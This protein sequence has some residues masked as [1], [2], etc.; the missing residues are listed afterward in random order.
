M[1]N[2]IIRKKSKELWRKISPTI[3]NLSPT[4]ASKMLYTLSTRK[5]LNI[6]NPTTFNE[7]LMWLKLNWQNPLVVKCADKYE[8]RDYVKSCGHENILTKL[9]GVYQSPDEIIWSDLPDKFAMKCTHG[10]GF[11]IIC[12]NKDELNK[13]EAINKLEQWMKTRYVFEAIEIQYDKMT[14]RIICEE[15]IETEAGLL[16][17]DYKIYCFNGEP[18]LTLVCTERTDNVKLDF[19]DLEWNQMDIGANGWESGKIPKKPESYNEMIKICRD[20]AKPFPFVRIDFY[21][22]NGKPI[23][24]EMTFTPAGCAARYYN[25]KGLNLLG[26]MIELP[27]KYLD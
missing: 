23:L 12:D 11:N 8:V 15:Y 22:Y 6:N 4:M 21:D 19:M 25:N 3:Y 26:D 24:G 14:P 18:K 7:K 2:K 13:T 20:L 5:I 17:N 16:P 9:Y 27:E 10:C 1:Q